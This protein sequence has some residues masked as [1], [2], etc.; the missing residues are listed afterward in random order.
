[1]RVIV[2]VERGFPLAHKR[3]S[4]NRGAKPLIFAAFG[5]LLDDD[6]PINIWTSM[7]NVLG[8]PVDQIPGYW[9]QVSALQRRDAFRNCS[10]SSVVA[11]RR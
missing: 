4:S 7:F 9:W 3:L 11:H 2:V 1:M 5:V 10:R 8:L 6:G